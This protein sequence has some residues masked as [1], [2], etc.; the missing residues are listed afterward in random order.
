MAVPVRRDLA[1]QLDALAQRSDQAATK[2]LTGLMQHV[3]GLARGLPEPRLAVAHATQRADDLGE[4]L[5]RAASAQ[6]RTLE[7]RLDRAFVALRPPAQLV[8]EQSLRLEHRLN[9][10]A[11]IVGDRLA[12]AGRSL[13]VA[14]ARLD[15]APLPQRLAGADERVSTAAVRL[16]VAM[17]RRLTDATAAAARLGQLVDTLG[18]SQVLA[19]GYAIVR[20][21]ASGRVL[22]TRAAAIEHRALE[23]Q[24]VD[25]ALTVLRAEP[26]G[27]GRPRPE[28]Q[29][30]PA[31][32][33]LL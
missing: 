15:G 23:L 9:R 3:A 16:A 11:D 31:Q 13:T 1:Q 32:E 17:T 20:A 18:P 26:M 29:P 33:S 19:R 22:A 8:R 14:S 28:G 5:A 25:G 12:G 2:L 6:L 24:F 30:A 27:R 7:A 4:R 10:L 21:Q